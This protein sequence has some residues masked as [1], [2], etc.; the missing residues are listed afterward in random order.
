METQGFKQKFSQV[1]TW[2]II[3]LIAL[4]LIIGLIDQR[5]FDSNFLAGKIE[6]M[7]NFLGM[8]TVFCLFACTI[9]ILVNYFYTA[10]IK[11]SRAAFYDPEQKEELISIL[12]D[13]AARSDYTVFKQKV[14][15][16]VTKYPNYLSE[17][18]ASIL[19]TA[20]AQP[21]V[22]EQY[23]NA[24]IDNISKRYADPINTI[25]LMSNVAPF[26]GFF[27]TLLGLIKAF[28]DSAAVFA[29]EQ[30]MTVEA[31]QQLQVAIVIAIITSLIGV[32]LKII[33]SVLKHNLLVKSARYSDDIA[34]IPREVLYERRLSGSRRDKETV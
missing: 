5:L 32:G 31:F 3:G 4:L 30:A 20:L 12:K 16:N 34:E 13:P 33:G 8:V 26:L 25:M 17:I 7:I 11:V 15:E 9:V 14:N 22:L 29:R 23:F 28:A 27:G 1:H 19:P 10:M 24:K 21:F 6:P 18:V 2:I